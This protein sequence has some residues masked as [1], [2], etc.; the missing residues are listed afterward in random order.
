[1]KELICG[2][3]QIQRMGPGRDVRDPM[4][5]QIAAIGGRRFLAEHLDDVRLH[6]AADKGR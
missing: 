3:G 5:P 6:T 4:C 2:N 1:M